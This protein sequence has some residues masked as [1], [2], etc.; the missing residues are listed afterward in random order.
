M[1]QQLEVKRMPEWELINDDA[2][3]SD[4]MMQIDFSSDFCE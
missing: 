4:E 2:W 3:F 1:N